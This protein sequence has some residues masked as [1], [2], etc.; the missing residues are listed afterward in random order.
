MVPISW[1][2]PGD[3]MTQRML[4]RATRTLA[5]LSVLLASIFTARV[6]SATTI[7]GGNIINQTWSPAGNP[8]II[9]GDIIVPSGSTL[10]IQPGTQILIASSD[11]AASGLDTARVEI[12]VRGNLN[13]QGTAASPITF[14]A[15]TS[16]SASAWYGIVIDATT[17]ALSTDFIKVQN[18]RYGFYVS[19]GSPTINGLTATGCTYGAYV[20]SKGNLTLTNSILY[21]N[22]QYGVRA[23]IDGGIA[24][25]ISLTND[26]FYGNLSDAVYVTTSGASSLALAVTNTIITQNSGY[27]INRST[28]SSVTATVTYSD[29]WNN[30]S[31]N[32]F[33]V[34]A[35]TG[36]LST[37]P[38]FVSTGAGNLR[39]T[40]R[41]P[42]RFAGN[43]GGDIGALPYV[44]DPT[45]NLEGVLWTDT[46]LAAAGS[47]YT[48]TGDLTVPAGVTLTI[49]AGVTLGASSSDDMGSGL[50]TARVELIVRGTLL[51]QGTTASPV[52]FKA[53]TSTSASAWY[54]IVSDT[55]GTVLTTNRTT[56]TNARY[57]LY[58]SD[59]NPSVNGLTFTGCTYGAY[60]LGRG[61]LSF[62]N[63]IFH[64]NQQYGVRAFIDGGVASTVKLTNVDFYGNLSDAVYVTTSGASTLTLAVTNAII[65]QNS[66]YGINRSTGSS[67]TAAV[68]YSDVWN[69]SS[70]NFFNVTAGTGAL[71]VNP[72]YVSPSTGDFSLQ[73][74]S[75]CIDSGTSMGAPSADISGTVRPLDGDTINGPAYDMGSF[76]YAPANFCGDGIVGAGEVCDQGVLNGSYGACKTDCS[77]LG[78]RC[79]DG[80]KNGPEQCDD[81]NANDNDA[82]RNNC[83]TAKCGDGVVQ[84]GVEQCDDGNNTDTDACRNNCQTAKCGDGVVLM[85]VEQCDD[86]NQVDNDACR[87]NCQ[88]AKCGDGVVQAGEQCDDGNQV[89]T[90]ACRNNCQTAKCG[91]G[92][93]QAGE[94]CDDGNQVDTDAC[95]NNCQT[96]KCGDGVVQTGVEQCDDGNG[97]D[98]DG[99]RNNCSLPSCGDGVVSGTEQCDD[100]NQIE[101]DGCT[102]TCMTAKC[103][104][105]IV[106]AG[107]EECD[108]GNQ[109]DNDGCTNG[110]KTPTCGDGIVQ[111]GEA[112][113][114]GNQV[115]TDACL[116]D[117]K[118]A[119]CGDGFVQAGVEECDD[120]NATAGDG[121]TAC[122]VDASTT[123]SSSSSSGTGGTGGAGGSP[124]ASSSSASSSVASGTGGAGGAG[125]AGGGGAGGSSSSGSGG[126]GDSGGCGCKAAGAADDA[127]GAGLLLA[128]GAMVA[129][130][131]RRRNR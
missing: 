24:S 130:G 25:T 120:G 42:A 64:A 52:V 22:Q 88:A 85:G 37:N 101:T 119:S 89:D 125:G 47:P 18:A 19:D 116:N 61:S 10:T 108:D 20:L 33:N 17:A 1:G 82:C 35:G 55:P 110:C 14:Q 102:N 6:A 105:G 84:T 23:F 50:D 128:I 81:G 106:R 29:V 34:T 58:V 69:N 80:V 127:P 68:T 12:T 7:N 21:A 91:D 87:N 62:T 39:I 109:V 78:P 60:V 44:N 66:G 129:V 114:D 74:T 13:A 117:C 45:P 70:G 92:V 15:Q 53:A 59:G 27:G 97:N 126:P 71:S 9:Q 95:R 104:D 26:T 63:S 16:T 43:A 49:P 56:I 131:R 73:S 96:A 107:V 40:S 118:A 121:C 100:G 111:A 124:S 86:G 57:G 51:T 113:D 4:A 48:I 93:V 65:T 8:Y 41:S 46:T 122:K 38:L 3:V 5:I 90:D 11:G 99:C 103:G 75:Q 83:Q 123:S 112:C 36:V 2:P 67:V 77:G 94:Q 32:F 72:F 76:E 115:E 54:G 28:G 98:G 30:S 79:G 31:G